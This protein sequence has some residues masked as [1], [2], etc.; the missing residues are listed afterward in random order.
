MNSKQFIKSLNLDSF[1]E[2]VLIEHFKS[3]ERERDEYEFKYLRTLKDRSITNQLLNASIY[4][5]EQKQEIIEEKNLI[6]KSRSRRLRIKIVNLRSS[7][8]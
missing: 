2:K 4:D 5:L 8:K 7:K 3:I 6:W 1:T